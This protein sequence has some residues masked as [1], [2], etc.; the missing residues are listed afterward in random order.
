M[1]DPAALRAS[2]CTDLARLPRVL[3]VLLADLT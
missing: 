1:I 3:D 2:A